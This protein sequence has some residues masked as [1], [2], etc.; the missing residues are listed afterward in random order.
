MKEKRISVIM[1]ANIKKLEG[2]SRLDT[3]VF[4]KPSNQE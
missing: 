2:V 3:I 4:N 1:Q